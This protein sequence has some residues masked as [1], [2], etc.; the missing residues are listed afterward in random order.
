M[1]IIVTIKPAFVKTTD[2]STITDPITFMDFMNDCIRI[3]KLAALY[4]DPAI[5]IAF[6]D[7]GT[8]LSSLI[9]STVNTY[10]DA[11]IEANE[12]Q[13]EIAVANGLVWMNSYASKVE[14]IANLPVNRT[15]QGQAAANILFSNLN[16]Q[17]LTQVKKGTPLPLDL[18]GK[19]G[20]GLGAVDLSIIND[21]PFNPSRSLLVSVQQVLVTDPV[22]APSV[23]TVV[24]DQMN[25]QTFGPTT[26]S[27][28]F[29]PGKGRL[30]KFKALVTGV[31]H[32]FYG[33]CSNGKNKNSAI[34]PKISVKL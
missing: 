21:E 31:Y 22:T 34:S 6:Y 16:Y 32:D 26:I 11:P 24:G 3:G 1:P 18:A 28:K 23:V 27:I 19:I 12:E 13:V 7:S 15:T 9:Q 20:V 33:F 29:I 17:A 25:I 2:Y 10:N 5:P 8:L 14:V 4:K 30:A